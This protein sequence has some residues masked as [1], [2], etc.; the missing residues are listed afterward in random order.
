MDDR[1]P[2]S[3]LGMMKRRYFIAT[4]TV[5]LG[6]FLIA[7]LMLEILFMIFEAEPYTKLLV[8]FVLFVTDFVATDH[9]INQVLKD[10]WL[11]EAP[12]ILDAI[13][14]PEPAYIPEGPSDTPQEEAKATEKKEVRR[15]H[16]TQHKELEAEALAEQKDRK[17]EQNAELDAQ[18]ESK[19]EQ[20]SDS[21]EKKRRWFRREKPDK[22]KTNTTVGEEP[23][24]SVSAPMNKSWTPDLDD[25]DTVEFE[26]AVMSL[27]QRVQKQK[28]Q[29][30][31]IVSHEKPVR[32]EKQGHPEPDRNMKQEKT[33]EGDVN[34]QNRRKRRRRRSGKPQHTE[35]RTSAKKTE[36]AP[37][38]SSWAGSLDDMDT[39]EISRAIRNISSAES[40]D[41]QSSGTKKRRPHSSGG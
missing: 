22:E 26:D 32:T 3:K 28:P 18:P 2:R 40:A 38:K 12:D 35:E 21:T 8:L 33:P 1:N 29:K 9:I 11:R 10:R 13:K 5:F 37:K 4:L 14:T 39:V 20:S 31:E 15:F 24:Q 23:K 16:R 6:I 34:K 19:A 7:Y 30:K 17:P 36:D 25:M 27:E 41:A